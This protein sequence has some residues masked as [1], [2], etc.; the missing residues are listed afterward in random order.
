VAKRRKKYTR[1]FRRKAVGLAA[2]SD[3]PI[4]EVARDLDVNYTTLYG[5][6]AGSCGSRKRCTR[7]IG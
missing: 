1:E 7:T 5:L 4:S 6:D 2:E 3:R